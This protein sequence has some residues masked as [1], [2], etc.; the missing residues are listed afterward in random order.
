MFATRRNHSAETKVFYEVPTL[1]PAELLRC[2]KEIQL[3][4][5]EEDLLKPTAARTQF[6]FERSLDLLMGVRSAQIDEVREKMLENV[7]QPVSTE[8]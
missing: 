8:V 1:S 4:F 7:D 3:P 5:T 6:L 2:L